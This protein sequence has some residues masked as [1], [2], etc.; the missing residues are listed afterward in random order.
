MESTSSAPLPCSETG[1]DSSL[2]CGLTGVSCSAGT[3]GPTLPT[4]IEV[5]RGAGEGIFTLLPAKVLQ[6]TVR[7]EMISVSKKTKLGKSLMT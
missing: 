7:E 6:V 2:F 4:R 5:K 3:I 1:K